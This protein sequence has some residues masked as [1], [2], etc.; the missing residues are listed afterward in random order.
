M[1]GKKREK[2]RRAILHAAK[3]LY[4]RR[5]IDGA[6]FD[7]IASAAGVCR[8]TV[9]NHYACADELHAALAAAEV[10]EL[11][12]FAEE[13]E[14]T[15]VALVEALLGRLIDDTVNYPRVMAQLT[16]ATVLGP[17]GGVVRIER[18]IAGEYERA[19]GPLGQEGGISA[20]LLA[21]MTLGLYYGQ[22]NALLARGAPFEAERMRRDM[23]LMLGL[24]LKSAQGGR[25][26]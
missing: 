15:G 24:L 2:T 16:N 12:A 21:Q 1:G 18:L 19:L 8:T 11:L 22:V 26:R 10:E 9:F 4:E 6:T 14:H 17:G 23:L 3:V 5:G 7:D 13:S 20:E 25:E